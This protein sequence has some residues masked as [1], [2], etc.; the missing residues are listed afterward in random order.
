MGEHARAGNRIG[1]QDFASRLGAAV[2]R[3]SRRG[4][5]IAAAVIS[6]TAHVSV[7]TVTYRLAKIASLTGY[8][9][10]IPAQ[11]L[12]LHASVVGARMLP[13]PPETPVPRT[14]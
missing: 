8:D 6:V 2:R 1:S 13:W 5:A 14:E 3:G 12:T 10:T 4:A 11:R 9:P 7:R